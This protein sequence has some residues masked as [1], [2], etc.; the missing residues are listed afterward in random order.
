MRAHAIPFR[1]HKIMQPSSQQSDEQL[2]WNCLRPRFKVVTSAPMVGA[3]LLAVVTNYWIAKVLGATL[4]ISS[5]AAVADN[6][7]GALFMVLFCVSMAASLFFY[8]VLGYTLLGLYLR[9][10]YQCSWKEARYMVTNT[11]Y[12]SAW[13]A[14]DRSGI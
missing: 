12:P 6:P 2:R 4:G 7:N 1:F 8:G 14:E 13:Y 3:I 10:S 9:M 5:S 11:Q